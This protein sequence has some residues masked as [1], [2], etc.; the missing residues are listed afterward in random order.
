MQNSILAKLTLMLTAIFGQFQWRPPFWLQNPVA[1]RRA[2]LTIIVLVI[3]CILASVGYIWYQKLPK[4]EYIS[5]QISSPKITPLTDELIPEPLT[6]EF[7]IDKDDQFDAKS[8]APIGKVEQEV[9]EGV[10]ISPNIPGTWYWEED[11]K[12]TFTPTEDWPAGQ[13]YT[14]RFNKNFFASLANM[15]AMQYSFTTEPLQAT[16]TEFKFYQDPT[17]PLKKETVATLSFNYPID[18]DSLKDKIYLQLQTLKNTFK[19]SYQYEIS[20][21]KFKRTVYVHSENINLP[22]K[23]RY[24]EL[25]LYKGIKAANGPSKTSENIKREILIP[26]AGSYFKIDNVSARI[27]RNEHDQPKQILIIDSTVG[28][29]ESDIQK[30]LEVYV[31]PKDYPATSVDA[32]KENYRWQNP[33]EI[34]EN[35][36]A[37]ATKL[38][39]KSIPTDQDYATLHS[40][41]FNAPSDLYLYVRI[42]KGIPGFGDY[43]LNNDYSAVVPVPPY[44]Q[45]IS[46]M[47]KGALLALTGEKKLSMII[48]G[49]P[50]VKFS[51]A[52]V[53]TSDI[54]HLV[55][56]TSGQFSNPY[57]L[58]ENFNK[59]NISELFSEIRTF[60]NET[61]D[62]DQYTALD[63]EKYLSKDT[64]SLG[65][66]LLEAT[67]WDT[68][69]N[70]PLNVKTERLILVTDLGI[71]AK[72]NQ[73]GTQDIFVQSITK[74]D[75]VTGAKVMVLGKN[76]LPISSGLTS[77]DGH[78]HFPDLSDF[79]EDKLPTV[80]LVTLDNDIS[81]MPFNDADRELNYSRFDIGGIQSTDAEKTAL[82]AF[83][84]S[85]RGIYRPSDTAHIAMIV[86]EMYAKNGAPGVPLEL[87]ITDP[88]GVNVLDQKLKLDSLGFLSVDFNTNNTSPTGQY[89]ANLFIVKDNHPSNLLGET[90]FKV[91]EFLPDRMRINAAFSENL[92]A[93]WTS[94]QGLMGKVNL[95]NLYGTP[96]QDRKISGKI[97]LTPKIIQFKQFP[98]YTFFDPLFDSKKP[99]KVFTETLTDTKTDT[100][101][102]ATLDFKLDRFEKATY[103]LTFFAEGF[104]AEGGRSVTTQISTIVSALPYFVGYK[105][106][107]DLTFI[108]QNSERHVNFIAVDPALKQLSLKNLKLEL[109]EER[110]I[111]TL[112]KKPDQTYEYQSIMQTTGVSTDS[113]DIKDSGRDYTLP[114]DKLGNFLIVIRDEANAELSRFQY[115]VVGNSQ[116]SLPKDAEMTV[117]LNKSN[118]QP[119]ETIAMEIAAPYTGAGLISIES[120]TVNAFRWF[121]SNTTNSLQSI[122]IPADLQGGGYVNIAFVRD[123]NSPDIVMSPLSFNIQPFSID[124]T[125]SNINI[126]LTAPSIARPGDDLHIQYQSDK[127]GKII[128]FAVDEGILQVAKYATPNPLSFFFQKRALQVKTQQILDQILPKF[129]ADRELSAVGGDAGEEDLSHY[130]NP[131][132]RKT[133][134]PVVYWSQ[135]L[136][137]DQN[138]HELNFTVPDYFNGSLRIMAV[139]VSDNAVGS[140]DKATQ[141]RGDFVINP[142]VPTQVAPNDEF[143]ITASV[144][145]NIDDSEKNAPI[146][147]AIDASPSLEILSPKK[148]TVNISAR[149]ES[150]IHL[151]V[152]AKPV[153]GNA[154]ITF[155]ANLGNKKSKITSTLSIRPATPYQTTLVSGQ[156][157]KSKTIK[158]ERDLYAENQQ[159]FAML[160]TNPLIFVFGLER[161]LENFPYGCTE[162]LVSKAFPLL[163]MMGEPRFAK[164]MQ[165][166]TDKI[167]ATI[168]MLNQRQLS[169]GGFSYWPDMSNNANNNFASVYAMHFLTEAR[170]K[171]FYI[172]R[173]MFNNGLTFL[174]NVSTQNVESLDEARIQAYAIYILTRNEVVTTN[175]LTHLQLYLENHSD[176]K[177]H[178][179]ITNAYMAAT[180][181]LLKSYTAANQL[182]D[183]YKPSRTI[184]E[185]D[186]FYN[187]ELAN[188]E[189]LYL[190]A[191]HFP[192]RLPR[193]GNDL[194]MSLVDHMNT[195]WINTISSSFM[196][197]ALT[198]YASA[199]QMPQQANFNISETLKDRKEKIL[200]NDSNN[201]QR[202]S[203]HPEATAVNFN[204]PD[205]IG[206]FYQVM[207]SGFDIKPATSAI[208]QG[209]EVFR[210]YRNTDN[211]VVNQI[212]LGDEI[213]VHIQIRAIKTDS[214]SNIVIVDLLPGG[215]EVVQSSIRENNM[216]Y[217]DIR[218]DRVVFFGNATS[219][220]Q[221][222]VY[223]IKATNIGEYLVPPIYAT[224]MYNPNVQATGESGKISITK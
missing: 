92:T 211:K 88:R 116:Q 153:L 38:P 131:F 108:K 40:Y 188:A 154:E 23:P 183:A 25:L 33:G 212:S 27:I 129:I 149:S 210:E 132:K 28:A 36:L 181:Q 224:S 157:T 187:E 58:N 189:Y 182:L 61:P 222:L 12:L 74:G 195:D 82:N 68:T 54:N 8:V 159:T 202:V 4:P 152:R 20:F 73:D 66:F 143:E 11:S 151:K 10:T 110:P 5:A 53:R 158:L 96:A 55:T 215:F 148:Q 141:I 180:Y 125:A 2:I 87:I 81:F 18:P 35:I 167:N 46:M 83:I 117:K 95:M 102:A 119:G 204:D 175:Y 62:R 113:F 45:E 201:F 39:L 178:E 104:E 177:W 21:D 100:D 207:Q 31:L 164:D 30:N 198:S 52:R 203:I 126:S 162:Q 78:V 155:Q 70:I 133:D 193:V 197:L 37:L 79:T 65:L 44:P 174:K 99:P 161:Y 135:I 173:E 219:N 76:G 140:I 194:V 97:L 134:L 9:T 57:F 138:P 208:K 114:T 184:S 51:I 214:E 107:G 128:V 91:S 98:Q 24:M 17:N 165:T 209:L 77:N 111:T 186:D 41:E 170:S 94:P 124:H 218:E 60:N 176:V 169:S 221:E 179:D 192:D 34:N 139:A 191:R 26:D 142:N 109:L 115:R 71:L 171:G 29:K 15:A 213:E 137:T 150:T 85:D 14:I 69:K 216:D 63:I 3:V 32:T 19:H 86:K 166:M 64:S 93:G 223:R 105:A 42:K 121:K 146:E 84:F 123:W 120:N 130:L 168:Q 190:I 185:R 122:P 49:L 145:N 67:G 118:F 75:P 6:I 43:T 50:A 90:T 206:F 106:D 7:G 127:P 13:T 144:S 48:R 22:D 59:Q 72:H 1:K 147:I 16:V 80:Y 89:T 196:S 47:H 103:Q 156:A 112:V 220:T 56:Q 160:S 136:D 101:G 205:K 199:N 217:V 172:S 163:A 200:T